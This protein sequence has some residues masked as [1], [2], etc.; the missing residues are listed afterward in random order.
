MERTETVVC[1]GLKSRSCVKLWDSV[2]L[3]RLCD[4]KQKG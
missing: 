4:R 1:T 2:A 3:G